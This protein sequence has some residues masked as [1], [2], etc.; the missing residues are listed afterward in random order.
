[1]TQTQ[2]QGLSEDTFRALLPSYFSH[3]H[4]P[5]FS[6]HVI[7]C[8][9]EIPAKDKR[10]VGTVVVCGVAR[11]AQT[12]RALPLER[13]GR[14]LAYVTPPLVTPLTSPCDL[15]W[16]KW[17]NIQPWNCLGADYNHDQD[18][19]GVGVWPRCQPLKGPIKGSI[20]LSC[21]YKHGEGGTF[22]I[23]WHLPLNLLNGL[24]PE[25]FKS[26][27]CIQ[28]RKKESK[29][30]MLH[31]SKSEWKDGY[32]GRGG[33]WSRIIPQGREAI[34]LDRA[35]RWW[36]WTEPGSE[37]VGCCSQEFCPLLCFTIMFL[38]PSICARSCTMGRAVVRKT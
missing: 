14:L 27:S 22:A 31:L 24:V 35:G 25:S 9:H 23:F 37:W 19:V 18:F 32:N 38:L 13:P 34:P 16:Q 3:L 21:R 11:R 5:Y 33:E 26:G 30:S 36:R 10:M 8:P 17:H 12:A 20:F 4:V 29:V 28:R 2:E 7:A 6:F 1:M 15:M